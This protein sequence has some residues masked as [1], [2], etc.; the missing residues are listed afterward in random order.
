MKLIAVS[1]DS[2]ENFT[3][4]HSLACGRWTDS[5]VELFAKPQLRRPFKPG[6]EELPDPTPVHIHIYNRKLATSAIRSGR[7]VIPD[8]V[9]TVSYAHGQE[10]I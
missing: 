2:V 3:L 8:T 9:L 10:P 1:A 7:F 4:V 6:V 5:V